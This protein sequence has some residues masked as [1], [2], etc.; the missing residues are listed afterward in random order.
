MQA[1]AR[2]N[3]YA[4]E[5][6]FSGVIKIRPSLTSARQDFEIA[7]ASP[8]QRHKGKEATRHI[9]TLNKGL[10]LNYGLMGGG[11]DGAVFFSGQDGATGGAWGLGVGG[12]GG[13]LLLLPSPLLPQPSPLLPSPPWQ[14]GSESSWTH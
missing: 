3:L 4:C 5:H 2:P 1:T 6:S 9:T 11:G 10:C 8:V 12:V 13:L 14:S 7:H